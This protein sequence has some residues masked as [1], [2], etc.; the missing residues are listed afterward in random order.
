MLVKLMILK[1]TQSNIE[2]V[3]RHDWSGFGDNRWI[4]RGEKADLLVV[5]D[6]EG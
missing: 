3:I 5:R 6:V 1:H 4:V 2:P